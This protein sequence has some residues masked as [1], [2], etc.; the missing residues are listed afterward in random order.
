MKIDQVMLKGMLGDSAVGQYGAGVRLSEAWYFIPM[1]VCSSALPAIVRSKDVSASNLSEKICK[2]Y[3]HLILV[4]VLISI[5][6]SLLSRFVVNVL[7][8]P[9]YGEAASVLSV[10]IWAS[11]FVFLGVASSQW[12]LVENLQ[13]VLFFNTALGA[14]L[15]IGLNFVLIPRFGSIGAAWA[16]LIA[17]A[18]V[19]YFSML[20]WAETRQNFYLLS[21]SFRATPKLLITSFRSIPIWRI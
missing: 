1:V 19:G 16:T 6:V 5:L 20:I 14:V 18:F 12:L 4:A 17:Q 15:N 8:G 9:A 3:S 2:L 7:Y 21:R 13:R 10:H 11:V